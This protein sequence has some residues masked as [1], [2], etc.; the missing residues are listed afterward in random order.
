MRQVLCFGEVL[1]DFLNID[2]QQDGPL[3]LKNYRQYPGGAP[4]NAAVAIAKLGGKAFFAGQVG[5]DFFGEF[6]TESLQLYNV[7]TSFMCKHPHAKTAMAFVTLSPEGER[8]FSFYRD[9]TADVLFNEEQISSDWFVEGSIF[10]FCSNTLTNSNIASSTK[11]AVLNAKK[12]NNIISFDVNL[13]HDLWPVG[14]ADIGLV[15]EFIFNA[16]LVKFSR[17][18][19]NYLASGDI[20][21]FIKQV[22]SQGISLIVITDGENEI[23]YFYQSEN[24]SEIVSSRIEVP[25]VQVVD[26]TAGGDS[27]TGALLFAISKQEKS[28]E[29]IICPEVLPDLLAFAIA[30]GAHTVTKPGAF[31]ALPEFDDVKQYW[32]NKI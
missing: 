8:S 5:D 9:D 11:A 21:T 3:N 1:I 20:D 13:R 18:E 27:F 24:K 19:L 4:A 7:D 23:E 15:N 2:E 16:D 14:K 31:P 32:S 22:F 10:H 25:R 30:C 26:T 12:Q 6:L 28:L 17:E 29:T